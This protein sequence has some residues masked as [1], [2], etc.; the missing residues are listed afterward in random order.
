MAAGNVGYSDTRSFSGS[1]LGDIAGG[2][3]DRIGNSMQMARAER[4][5]AAKAM[6][7]GGRNDGITQQEFDKEYGKGYFFK[8]ALGS[9]FGGDRI[10]RTRGYFE[11]NPPAGRDP[12]GTRESRFSAGFDYAAKEGL[13]KGARPLQGPKA[14]EYLYAYDRRYADVLGDSAKFKDDTLDKEKM[15]AKSSMFGGGTS[16]YGDTRSFGK[17][18]KNAVPVEDKELNEKI[19][20]SLSGIEVQMTRLEQKMNSSDGEDGQVASLVSANSKAIVAG[21]TG[22]HAALSSFLGMMQKQTKAIKDGAEAKK[23]AEEKAEDK[24]NR[25][26]EELGAEGL[27]GGAENAGV[28]GLGKKKGGGG[29]WGGLL[30]GLF[31]LFTGR[32]WM[33]GKPTNPRALTR[34]ARMKGMGAVRGIGS[35]LIGP[36]AGATM[37]WGALEGGFPR[38]TA[39]YDQVTGPNAYYND[40]RMKGPRPRFFGGGSMPGDGVGK[41]AI[42]G[43]TPPG[44]AEALIPMTEKV[45]KDSARAKLQV[46][47]KNKKFFSDIY[48][49]GNKKFYNGP[50]GWKKLGKDLW[51]AIKGLFGGG[52]N[53]TPDDRDPPPPGS[54]TPI[55]L[56]GFSEQEISDL[57]R[58][59]AAEAGDKEGQ[60]L[61]LNSIL[62]RYRQIKSGKVSPSQ[63][64]IQGKTKDEVTLTDIIYAAN[65]YQPI[66]DGSFNRVTADQGTTALNNAVEGGGLDPNRV[67]ENLVSGGMSESDATQVAVSDSFY[68]PSASSNTPFPGQPSVATDN[69]HVF[70]S[71]GI[72]YK[73]EDLSSLTPVTQTAPPPETPSSNPTGVSAE[74]QAA[75]MLMNSVVPGFSSSMNN[76]RTLNQS[77]GNDLS[78]YRNKGGGLTLSPV[79]FTMPTNNTAGSAKETPQSFVGLDFNSM[80]GW[81]FT[82]AH[83][84]GE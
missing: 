81:T 27:D 70:M 55:S 59:I 65:Q 79:K 74:Q 12:T 66:R 14:P 17:K 1:L 63:W 15:K 37:L 38:P 20:S 44:T 73:P 57:G 19:A 8:R 10:A 56:D 52:N 61:V 71:S 26:A 30:G 22:I 33:R 23:D 78:G 11:K 67:K 60:A 76:L 51:N 54:L 31:D 42:I 64:G 35:R 68:N 62:N 47:K 13:I 82:P 46:M 6:N 5:N 50:D 72:G 77:L 69:G 83:T 40:P 84:S 49:D 18:D 75:E 4:A 45:F 36:A 16:K 24:A 41:Q 28:T 7:V 34:L 9:N 21:F 3:K 58:I 39:R 25:A 53:N 48:S 43:D 2:I 29:F 32:G 80:G